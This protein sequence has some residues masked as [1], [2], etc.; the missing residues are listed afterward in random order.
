M[1]RYRRQKI[2]NKMNVIYWF[3][4]GAS[5]IIIISFMFRIAGFYIAGV[6]CSSNSMYP[7]LYCGCITLNK[8]VHNID[9]IEVGDIIVFRYLHNDT[10]KNVVHQVIEK[11]ESYLTTRG[12]NNKRTDGYT[13]YEQVLYKNIGHFCL[14]PREWFND[15]KV[16]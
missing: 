13:F 7:E 5:A 1:K 10:L 15:S 2:I 12:V 8:E 11:E 3:I 4:L 9:E 6:D 14:F 16:S